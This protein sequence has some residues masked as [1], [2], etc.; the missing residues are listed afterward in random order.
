MHA[1]GL[2]LRASCW[3]HMQAE[4]VLGGRARTV[5]SHSTLAQQ[6]ALYVRE[7][8]YLCNG[9]AVPWL[10]PRDKTAAPS[11]LQRDVL[12]LTA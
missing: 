5:L 6:A 4:L 3:H 12:P 7:L 2:T 8:Q 1:A 10:A 11:L 9:L